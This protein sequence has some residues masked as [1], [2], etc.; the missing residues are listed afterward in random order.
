MSVPYAI[1]PARESDLDR[2][3]V[4]LLALQDHLEASN[5]D[6]W[7]MTAQSRANLKGQLAGRLRAA[8]SCALVAEHD[9]D[10]VVGVIFGR[11]LANNRYVPALAGSIDQAYVRPDHRRRGVGTRLVSEL[12]RFFAGEGVDSLTLRYVID[13]QEA[14]A[15]W[16]AL[17]FAPR[18]VTTGATRQAVEAKLAQN[19]QG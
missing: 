19:R 3:A 13:N 14:A 18:I 7:R 1:R 5:L 11:V 9:A 17:G 2:L 12:C 16:T 6:L 8:N 10:G 15:F 4:L